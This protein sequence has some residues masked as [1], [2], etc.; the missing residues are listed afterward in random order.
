MIATN[1][2]VP[3][4]E[5]LERA[6]FILDTEEHIRHKEE[7]EKQIAAVKEEIEL[8]NL[9]KMYLRDLIKRQCWDAMSTKGRVVKVK[10]GEVYI[11]FRH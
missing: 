11:T 8:S 10:Y 9:A 7:E 3:D 1:E 6:E 5:R 2:Q 4:I